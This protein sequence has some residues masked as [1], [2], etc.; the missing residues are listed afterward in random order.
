MMNR[1]STDIYVVLTTA[2]VAIGLVFVVPPNDSSAR[3]LTLPLVLV[4]PG[5]ALMAAAFPSR[6][7]GILER[8]TLTLGLSLTMVILGGLLLNLTPFGLST[9]SWTVL[10]SGVTLGLSAV[11]LVRRRGQT[12]VVSDW[13]WTGAVGLTHRQV[14]LLGLAAVIVFGAIAMSIIGAQRQTYA[15][16]TQLWMLSAGRIGTENTVRL[17]VS[18]RD[19]TALLYRLT[20]NVDG[21]AIKEWPSLHLRPSEI[22]EVT[23]ELPSVHSAQSTRVEADLYR[24]DAPTKIY[25]HVV[26]WLGT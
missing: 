11:A 10:L 20:V 9:T 16:F 1:R 2:V 22:W 5:Y 18:D 4:L 17:G 13:S 15:G 24:T 3:I 7:L 26:L 12:T 21:K 23:L 19:A 8:L 6:S 25:R 14:L